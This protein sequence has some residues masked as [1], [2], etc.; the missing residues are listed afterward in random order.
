MCSF[1]RSR[2]EV[3]DNLEKVRDAEIATGVSFGNSI[4]YVLVWVTNFLYLVMQ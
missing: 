2:D 1:N 4:I 3:C